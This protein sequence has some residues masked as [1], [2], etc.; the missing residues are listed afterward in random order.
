MD[1]RTLYEQIQI[2]AFYKLQ[3]SY[4]ETQTS[5]DFYPGWEKTQIFQDSDFSV[6]FLQHLP[7]LPESCKI[8]IF[9]DCLARFL[10][11]VVFLDQGTSTIF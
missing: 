7:F 2:Y 11:D 1:L 5:I 4:S 10:Q 9:H 8:Y 3:I 6:R